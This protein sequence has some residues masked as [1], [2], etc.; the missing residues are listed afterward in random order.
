MKSEL[1]V[2]SDNDIPIKTN[3][4]SYRSWYK[5]NNTKIL[6]YGNQF[7]CGYH[8]GFFTCSA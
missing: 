4:G 7:F 5:I 6:V 1:N 3:N 8:Q 2:M